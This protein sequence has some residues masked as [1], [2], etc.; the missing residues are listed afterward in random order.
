MVLS[1]YEARR[2]QPWALGF[3]A[4]EERLFWEQWCGVKPVSMFAAPPHEAGIQPDA[5][6]VMCTLIHSIRINKDV[7]SAAASV[8]IKPRVVMG[9]GVDLRPVFGALTWCAC[10][11]GS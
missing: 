2:K 5:P 3:G 1:F 11:A 6:S 4:Q 10:T 8:S 7:C 9:V